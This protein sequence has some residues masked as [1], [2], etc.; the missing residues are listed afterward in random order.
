MRINSFNPISDG[1]STVLI[2]GTMPGRDSL[3]HS[4]YYGDKNNL[5]WDIMFR[6]CYPDW[7]ND[8]IVNVEYNVKKQLL[9]SNKIAL[10][11]VL[12]FCER[13]GSSD[14]NI[15]NET[16]N[17]FNAFF[18]VHK[19]IKAIFFNGQKAESYFKKHNTNSLIAKE[20]QFILQSTSPQNS[21]NSFAILKEWTQIRY[22]I[23]T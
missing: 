10:W 13:K 21:T 16:Y 18:E 7:K 1:Q 23:K 22:F 2:L 5:F 11:D 14:M 12:E 19:N 3:K 15:K 4:Q 8:E 9:L 17:D 6:V 20:S